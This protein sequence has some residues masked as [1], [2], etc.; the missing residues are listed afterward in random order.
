MVMCHNGVCL[1]DLLHVCVYTF[2]SNAQASLKH[3]KPD[4]YGLLDWLGH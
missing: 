1:F 4:Y 2:N 3:S